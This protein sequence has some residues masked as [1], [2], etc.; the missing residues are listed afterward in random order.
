MPTLFLELA[1]GAAAA[2]GYAGFY[3]GACL[4][5]RYAPGSRL[6]LHQD[7]NEQDFTAPI[8]SVSLGLPANFCLAAHSAAAGQRAWRSNTEMSWCGADRRGLTITACCP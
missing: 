5:N 8:V 1:I 7:K 3:A 4:I 2:A 6:S